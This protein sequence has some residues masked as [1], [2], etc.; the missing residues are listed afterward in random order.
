MYLFEIAHKWFHVEAAQTKIDV[1]VINKTS[2]PNSLAYTQ[3]N[4]LDGIFLSN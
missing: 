3:N 4:M 1:Q 2:K